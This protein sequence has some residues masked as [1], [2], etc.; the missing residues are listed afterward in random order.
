MMYPMTVASV[1]TPIYQIDAKCNGAKYRLAEL[2]NLSFDG[3]LHRCDARGRRGAVPCM[4][5][6]YN[7]VTHHCK[8]LR[9]CME[10]AATK[11]GQCKFGYMLQPKNKLGAWLARHKAK[12]PDLDFCHYTRG[13]TSATSTSIRRRENLESTRRE[14]PRAP[15]RPRAA[16]SER[17]D[18]RSAAL[19]CPRSRRGHRTNPL[20]GVA[21]LHGH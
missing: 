14:A 20:Q 16:A 5:V 12:R 1:Y 19:A 4:T 3:C 7:F 10:R 21:L 18:L 9:E 11:Y 13:S 2:A 6:A 15:F 8:L 17:D